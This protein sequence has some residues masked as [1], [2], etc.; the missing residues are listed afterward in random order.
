M[1]NV[2]HFLTS[3]CEICQSIQA[4]D[5]TTS[6][7]GSP[8]SW[9]TSLCNQFDLILSAEF[10]MFIAWGQQLS[11]LYNNA[12][13]PILGKRH[14]LAM[15]QPLKEIWSEVWDEV[16]PIIHSALTG[17][18]SFFENMPLQIQR[19]GY[20]EQSWF[21]FS[22]SP[23]RGDDGNIAGLFCVCTETTRE[24]ILA[25]DRV[26]E[27]E[28][29]KAFFKQAPGYIA[30]LQGP[31]HIFELVNDAYYEVVGSRELIGK[32]VREALPE[33]EG[34]SY[35]ELLD[36]V[37][38]TGEP[39]VGRGVSA[40]IRR[41]D[42]EKLEQRYLD[43]V[44]QPI[45]DNAGNVIGI[46]VEG[47]DVTDA[48]FAMA[49]LQDSETRLLQLAN[50]IPHLAWMANPDGYIHWYN[51][52]W[53]QYT[54]TTIETMKGWGW[55]SVHDPEILPNVIKGWRQSL[56][57]GEPWEVS[58]PLRSASGEYRIFATSAAPLRNAAGT[59]VQWFGTNTDV[60]DS[61]VAR[62]KL[63]EANRR[64]DEFL[65]ML[66]HELRN[67]LSPIITAAE[68]LN[69]TQ[70]ANAQVLNTAKIISRQATH[71]AKLVDDLLDMSRVTRGLITL[72]NDILELSGV[73]NEALEQ[74]QSSAQAKHHTLQ[75][76]FDESPVFIQGDL[77]RLIQIFSNLLSNAVRY[78]PPS[79]L[80]SLRTEIRNGKVFISVADNGDGIPETLAPHIFDLFT[81]GARTSDRSQGG[82]GLGLPLVK[83]LV[84]LHAGKVTLFSEGAEKGSVF[85]VELPT[86]EVNVPPNTKLPSVA[87]QTLASTAHSLMVV[88]DNEDAAYMLSTLLQ[89]IGHNVLVSH[90]AAEALETA[91]K[92]PPAMLFL[93]IGLPDMDGY[94]LAKRLKTINATASAVLVALTGYGQPEDKE[95]AFNAGFDYYLVKPVKLSDVLTLVEK[96]QP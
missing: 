46:F 55:Q 75:F 42:T 69:L 86:V 44:Q 93:D 80:I 33:L 58:F 3:Q 88:D 60:T 85:T 61:L 14:P 83:S 23:A 34:Q 40:I 17:K 66:A 45:F 87:K 36:N 54:G 56:S 57:S 59:I 27:N 31:T 76:Q 35:F 70:S 9:H 22:Y 62:D 89:S 74:I 78:T 79:G 19:N 53:F 49:A 92:A 8:A 47:S 28:R 71:V 25:R 1:L 96:L 82:L 18:S 7:L 10:P 39:F 65:A 77:T 20:L 73:L 51:D 94:E 16:S 41:G 63:Q 24:V 32:P 81:Q 67:P 6:A 90:R 29:L 68:L 21:T 38:A 37:F 12:Y 84:E 4:F 30:V 48:V 13:I 2:P 52:R 95:K 91:R 64:K 50:T 11:L 26:K 43:F 15:G 72:R 5:W